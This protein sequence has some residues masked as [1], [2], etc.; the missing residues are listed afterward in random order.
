MAHEYPPVAF[1]FQLSFS[2]I[3]GT[4]DASFKEVSGISMEMGI[5]EITEG[6]NNA[7]KHR[8]PTSVKFSNLVLKRGLVPKD[9]EVIAWCKSTLEG[10][11]AEVIETKNITVHLLNENGDPLNSWSFMNAWPVKWAAADLH[12]MNNEVMI[13]TLEF[14]YS[15]F[16]EMTSP[17]ST[18]DDDDG[19][20]GF[21]L[22]N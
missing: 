4:V 7:F 13:E 3:S 1:Y 18:S 2:G 12:S 17:A 10:G 11:L 21:D 20:F 19:D 6:G 16:T 9:S 22:F 5:E 8:V 14:A 15:N